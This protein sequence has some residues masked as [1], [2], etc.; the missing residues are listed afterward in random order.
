MDDI[1]MNNGGLYDLED[2]LTMRIYEAQ[3]VHEDP[4]GPH[5]ARFSMGIKVEIPELNQIRH[6]TK[7][8]VIKLPLEWFE[9]VIIKISGN[10]YKREE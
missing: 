1:F 4:E 9:H 5:S 7:N 2:G 3:F 8:I 10:G 6:Y